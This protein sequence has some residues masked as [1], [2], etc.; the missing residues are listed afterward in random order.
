[1]HKA[2]QNWTT[3]WKRWI[4]A[5]PNATTQEVFHQAG[6]MMENFGI[7]HLPIIPY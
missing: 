5:N 2:G 6:R 7:N 3:T 1:M 4:D